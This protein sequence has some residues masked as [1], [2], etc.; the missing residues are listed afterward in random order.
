MAF[1]HSLDIRVVEQ[2]EDGVTVAC[3]LRPELMN[4]T[5]V[6]HG[7]ITAAIADE[8]VWHALRQHYGDGRSTTTTELNVNYLRPIAGSKVSARTH[9]LQAGRTLCVGRVD[10]FDENKRLAAVAMVTYML[11]R[12]QRSAS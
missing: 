3:A 7:G 10:I 6:L 5:G 11:L 4:E 9:L 2:H 1:E 12:T 8:A